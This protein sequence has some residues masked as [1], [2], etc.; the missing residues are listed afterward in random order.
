MGFRNPVLTAED[1]DARALA[2][3][4]AEDAAAAKF[5]AENGIIP[6]SRLA[7][8]A[9]D[10]KTIT[11]ATIR[12]AAA[13]A[14]VELRSDQANR[15]RGYTGDA[16]ETTP[17]SFDTGLLLG[18]KFDGATSTD[19][20]NPGG[21]RPFWR[22]TPPALGARN[23][24]EASITAY[25]R[26]RTDDEGGQKSAANQVPASFEVV[27]RVLFT[28]TRSGG[29]GFYGAQPVFVGGLTSFAAITSQSFATPDDTGWN[30]G[31]Y[32]A[33]WTKVSF[34]WRRRMGWLHFS[35]EATR[36]SWGAGA[37]IVQ[38]AATETPKRNHRFQA[39][40]GL[41][42]V[43]LTDGRMVMADASTF[44]ALYVSGAYPL[45]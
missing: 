5:L 20:P 3:A 30:E 35:M 41:D 7:A 40:G 8:D 26:A 32:A 17:G 21:D 36:A 34:A 16:A 24:A 29:P 14:R 42:T 28:G 31:V 12:T 13:G 19:V 33:G 43:V 38:W 10:G 9:I 18:T 27:G 23:A 15:I 2:A 22:W 37:L 11:G 1:P 6:G 44:G 45:D 4:A 25:G 39:R